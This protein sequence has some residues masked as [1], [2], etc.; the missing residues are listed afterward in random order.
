M[1]IAAKLFIVSGPSGCGKT[2]LA[3]FITDTVP[4]CVFSKSMTTRPVRE[5]EIDDN[6]DHVGTDEF[7]RLISEDYFLEYEEVYRDRYYG[8]P[9]RPVEEALNCGKNVVMEID[10]RG[11]ARVKQVFPKQST[12]IFVYPPSLEVLKDRLTRRGKMSEED[13]Q[14][15]LGRAVMEMLASSDYDYVVVNDDLVKALSEVTQ[16]INTH[17]PHKIRE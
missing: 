1:T 5:G 2:T 3:K 6:Y 8:T 10:V 12:S 9:R 15:R 16:I 17:V 13:V 14:E 11:A 7:R 4:N